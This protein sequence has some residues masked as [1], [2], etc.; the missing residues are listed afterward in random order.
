MPGIGST[1]EEGIEH[2]GANLAT[3]SRRSRS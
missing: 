1:P 2:A 3:F